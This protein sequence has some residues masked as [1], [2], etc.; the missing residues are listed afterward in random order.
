MRDSCALAAVAGAC[1]VGPGLIRFLVE[2]LGF[3]QT[4]VYAEAGQVVHAELA[5]PP[6]GGVMLSSV[7]D[8]DLRTMQPGTYAANR[9][10]CRP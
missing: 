9:G 8:H 6:G 4:V 1:T 3:E 5:W 10:G 7:R 2:V